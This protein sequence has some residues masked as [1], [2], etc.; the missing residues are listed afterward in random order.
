[1]AV[2]IVDAVRRR[3]TFLRYTAGSVVATVC[4]EVTL[5]AAYGLFG[6]GPEVASS[7]AWVAG[8]LPNYLLN[9]RWAWKR[10]EGERRVRQAVVY[11]SITVATAALAVLA[12]TGADGVIRGHV[13]DRGQRALLLG[14]VYLAVY[15]IA[16][17]GKFVVFDKWV[18]GRGRGAA[19]AQG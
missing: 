13:A 12:T 10:R 7:A 8:A 1:M 9:R 6:A 3:G 2:V 4:S 14:I 19:R 5:L 18:F 15:G 11:W 16:F 17:I